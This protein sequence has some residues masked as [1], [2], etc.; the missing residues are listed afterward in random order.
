M[1]MKVASV[2]AL[3]AL[4]ACGDMS[5][6]PVASLPDD[7]GPLRSGTT[8]YWQG[9]TWNVKNG[10]GLGPGPNNWSSNNVWVDSNGYLHMK[11]SKVNGVWYAA[12]IGTTQSLGFGTYQWWVE[13]R[14]D[15]L[16]PNVVLG[17]FG[18][19][20]PDGANEM[21]IE[22]SRWGATG[23]TADNATY[24]V[25]PATTDSVHTYHPWRLSLSGTFT[26]QRYRW[27]SNRVYFQTL[28]GHRDNDWNQIK[29]WEFT[30]TSTAQQ[31]IPQDAMPAR[32]NLWLMNGS[33]PM[34]GQEV[35]I[36]IRKF[37]YTPL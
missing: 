21:D 33:A 1:R 17:L 8:L 16:D 29:S 7:A 36:V 14:I 2:L 25:W 10:T 35:E 3:A 20:G 27:E 15:L 9:Y 5:T 11:I 34:D 22:F 19:N 13:G 31:L 30:Q 26:T 18:Y 6:N 4:A 24:S 12:E 28:G 23:S 32:I 37:T